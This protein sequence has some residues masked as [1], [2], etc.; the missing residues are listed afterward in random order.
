MDYSD[1]HREPSILIIDDEMDTTT[2]LS[3][4]LR[5]T[6]YQVHTAYNGAKGLEII[7]N[8]P[9]DLIL[10][11]LMMPD[12][13]GWETLKALRKVSYAPVIILSARGTKKNVVSGF[14]NLVDDYIT[15]PFYMDE[16]NARIEAVLRRTLVFS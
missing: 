11:D 15:K 12:M 3:L 10:L 14:R 7:K 9:V 1:Y 2:L 5:K 16:V 4:M 6:G 13:D 8:N